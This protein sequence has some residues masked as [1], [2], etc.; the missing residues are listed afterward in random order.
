MNNKRQRST[1]ETLNDS[2][3][4]YLDYSGKLYNNFIVLP[5][6]LSAATNAITVSGYGNYNTLY[7]IDR[8]GGIDIYLDAGAGTI[9]N[10]AA[11]SIYYDGTHTAAITNATGAI[12]T[13]GVMTSIIYVLFYSSRECIVLPIYLYNDGGGNS[14]DNAFTDNGIADYTATYGVSAVEGLNDVLAQETEVSSISN[15][16]STGL[17]ILQ[18]PD[19]TGSGG[20][21]CEVRIAWGTG[22]ITYSDVLSLNTP[23][24]T[25]NTP[26]LT[27]NLIMYDASSVP[28]GDYI[29]N[30]VYREETIE[31]KIIEDTIDYIKQSVEHIGKIENLLKITSAGG[32][33]S[34][35]DTIADAGTYLTITIDANNYIEIIKE[36]GEITIYSD[37]TDYNQLNYITFIYRTL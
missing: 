7:G 21:P 22:A 30:Y 24:L 1:I 28:A 8:V 32:I 23:Y 10:S 6:D 2:L 18:L 15:D 27:V 33:N 36:N 37:S 35:S 17:T 29:Q 25:V 19:G 13:T 11:S 5:V 12:V 14:F 20:A 26:Y 16:S 4:N 34:T 3:N 9:T 31:Y